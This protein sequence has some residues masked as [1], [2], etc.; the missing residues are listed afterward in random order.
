VCYRRLAIRIQFVRHAA[1]CARGMVPTDGFVTDR[2][3]RKPGRGYIAVRS[4]IRDRSDQNLARERCHRSESRS[5]VSGTCCVASVIYGWAVCA[6]TPPRRATRIVSLIGA[7]G[8]NWLALFPESQR[9][10]WEERIVDPK[11]VNNTSE[12]VKNGAG[13]RPLKTAKVGCTAHGGTKPAP[14]VRYVCRFLCGLNRSRE[15]IRVPCRGSSA[16]LG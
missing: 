3:I 16:A 2:K 1:D 15:S 14:G 13:A 5:P 7:G 6:Y 11:L 10:D 4:L 8:W 12:D 9:G